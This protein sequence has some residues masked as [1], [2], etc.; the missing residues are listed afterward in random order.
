MLTACTEKIDFETARTEVN[1]ELVKANA[2]TTLGVTID[3]SQTWSSIQTGSVTISADA[4]M[5]DITKVQI[6]T[7]SPFF[8]EEAVVLNSIAAKKGDVVT[9]VYEAP[10][11]YTRLVAACVNSNGYYY[12]KGFNIGDSQVSLRLKGFDKSDDQS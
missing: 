7:E 3:P 12:V 6:L 4:D 5:D 8:N 2:E 11:I 10:N 1:Q 9:L